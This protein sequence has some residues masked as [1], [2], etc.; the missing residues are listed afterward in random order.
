MAS[1]ARLSN[2]Q[3]LFELPG[4]SKHKVGDCVYI[5]LQTQ[6]VTDTQ[7]NTEFDFSSVKS[8]YYSGYYLITSIK[9]ILTKQHYKMVIEAA[10]DSH[11]AKFG[12]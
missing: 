1:F 2:Y 8:K 5:D 4:N 3:V 7:E 11:I 9:H 10:K 12:K 6:I